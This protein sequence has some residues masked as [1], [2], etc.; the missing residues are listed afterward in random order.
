M[1]SSYKRTHYFVRMAIVVLFLVLLIPSGKAKADIGPKPSMSFSFEYAD[2]KN[3]PVVSGKLLLCEDKECIKYDE[4]RGP[5]ECAAQECHSLSLQPNKFYSYTEY[6][7]IV[8]AFKDKTRES[9]VFTKQRYEAQYTVTVQENGL[10]VVEKFS[11]TPSFF[12]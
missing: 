6:Q 4:F 9:N 12:D 5:F 7:K 11:F 2:G 10:Y 8:I 3:I 1:F